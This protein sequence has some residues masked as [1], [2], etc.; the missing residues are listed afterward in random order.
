MSQRHSLSIA[1]SAGIAFG[2]ALAL[3][4]GASLH[5][6]VVV[7]TPGNLL[8]GETTIGSSSFNA[9][10]PAS[11]A[12]NDFVRRDSTGQDDGLIFSDSDTDQR[13]VITGFDSALTEIRFFTNTADPGRL[14]SSLVIRG[15]TSPATTLDDAANNYPVLLYS[16]LATTAATFD[17]PVPAE[18]QIKYLSIPVTFPS[19]LQ[20]LHISLGSA[21][22][23]GDRISEVQAFVP[24]PAS[25]GLLAAGAPLLLNRRR[26]R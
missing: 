12:V 13:L 7:A 1:F 23:S 4:G 24:E 16:N 21:N 26:S 8:A 14:P 20:S 17:Q 9:S 11:A 25:L 22:G 2:C 6:D 5:A 10:Y 15:S 3:P 18:T 19:N